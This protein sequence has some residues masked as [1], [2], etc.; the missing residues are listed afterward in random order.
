MLEEEIV[1]RRGFWRRQRDKEIELTSHEF[2]IAVKILFQAEQVS[3]VC[4][5]LALRWRVA[6]SCSGAH[7]C[8]CKCTNACA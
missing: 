8:T 7:L 3:D 4:G 2:T 5:G 1:A 6:W